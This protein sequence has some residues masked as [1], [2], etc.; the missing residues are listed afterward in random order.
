MFQGIS[1]SGENKEN[2]DENLT[3]EGQI[4]AR[5][6]K[7]EL[8]G[9]EHTIITIESEIIGENVTIEIEAIDN[10]NKNADNSDQEVTSTPI[11]EKNAESSES[12]SP[13][14]HEILEPESYENL[15]PTITEIIIPEADMEMIRRSLENENVVNDTNM[16]SFP[17]EVEPENTKRQRVSINKTYFDFMSENE[18]FEWDS[19]SWKETGDSSSSEEDKP[20]KKKRNK[21][22]QEE[23]VGDD[24]LRKQRVNKKKKRREA[25]GGGKSYVKKDGSVV[26]E[27]QLL[28]NPCTGKNCGRKCGEISEQRRKNIFDHYWS[29]SAERKKDWLVAMSSKKEINRKRAKESSYRTTTF[30]YFINEGEGHR[31]VC[32]KFLLNTLDVTQRYVYYTLSNACMGCAKEEAR[33]KTV[34]S[35]KTPTQIKASAINFIKDLPALPSHY[36]R[37]D[38]TRLYL[39]TEFKNIK[40]LYRMYKEDRVSKGVDVISEK[41]FRYIFNNDFNL[42][43]H[44]PKKDKCIKC[45]RYEGKEK[46]DPEIKVTWKK[47]KFR[48]RDWNATVNF[49]RRILPYYARHLI[50]RRSLIPHMETA[51]FYIIPENMLCIIYAYMKV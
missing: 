33:G 28:P 40:N 32:L 36:C 1:W 5:D 29:L 7:N 14:N 8:E 4:L 10:E 24:G 51:C 6:L 27:K 50:C 2:S 9:S 22:L 43:F 37:K 46:T 25:R 47:K 39:P 12:E 19:T 3:T 41:I 30:E 23:K 17:D 15:Q 11:S 44:V 21:R 31:S 26:R 20:L 38:S 13:R 45:L 42:G 18:D 48:R 16:P 34:P 35:N 49:I